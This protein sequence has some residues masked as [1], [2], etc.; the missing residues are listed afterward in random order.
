MPA[1]PTAGKSQIT[2]HLSTGHG[3]P[4]RGHNHPNVP[5]VNNPYTNPS[6]TSLIVTL[7]VCIFQIPLLKFPR[8]YAINATVPT[9]RNTAR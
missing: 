7:H 9:T 8:P 3:F 4:H 1:L 5:A 6:T 2:T